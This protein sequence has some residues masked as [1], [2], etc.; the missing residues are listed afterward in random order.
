MMYIYN[1]IV[2]NKYEIDLCSVPSQQATAYIVWEITTSLLF[3]RSQR[4]TVMASPKL[5]E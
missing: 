2:E 3:S 1:V 5:N 4:V